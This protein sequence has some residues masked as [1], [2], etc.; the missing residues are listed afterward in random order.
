MSWRSCDHAHTQEPANCHA[1]LTGGVRHDL[2]ADIKYSSLIYCPQV[3]LTT[4][5]QHTGD[6]LCNIAS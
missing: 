4:S 2:H 5:T 6:A 1:G 3:H